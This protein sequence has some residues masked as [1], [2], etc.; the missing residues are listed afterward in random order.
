[1]SFL[2]TVL[3]SVNGD[4]W[5]G[6]SVL[7]G[8]VAIIEDAEIGFATNPVAFLSAS[9]GEIRRSRVRHYRDEAVLDYG[10]DARVENCRIERGANLSANFGKRGV[11]S[12]FSQTW[13]RADTL[14]WHN[15]YAIWI[16]GSKSY[17][18]LTL[19]PGTP[20][21]TVLIQECVITGPG[22]TSTNLTGKGIY[23]D[24]VCQN[25]VAGISSNTLTQWS[26]EALYLFK[27]ADIGVA[28]NTIENNQYGVLYDRGSHL[29]PS[30]GPIRFL[31]NDIRKSDNRNLK[32]VAPVGLELRN[33]NPALAGENTFQTDVDPQNSKNIEY[34]TVGGAEIDALLHA[35]RRSDGSFMNDPQA[36]IDTTFVLGVTNEIAVDPLTLSDPACSRQAALVQAT[37]GLAP[38]MPPARIGAL[39]TSGSVPSELALHGPVPNPGRAGVE[40]TLD[41]PAAFAGEIRVVVYDV[42]GRRVRE[43]VN[44]S[45]SPG[46]HGVSWNGLDATGRAAAPGAY[47]VRMEA[48]E[49]HVN[50]RVLLLR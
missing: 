10:S 14:S 6:I 2:S 28:C 25:F 16:D 44:R 43:L 23:L 46:R 40:L 21:E 35:W 48:G 5:L 7:D 49:F 31:K 3:D 9:I 11:H 26:K 15:E 24:W 29:G 13:I 12:V 33:A 39:E 27:S 38:E 41:V 47:F 42:G 20:T 19:P 4:D 45:L 36:V 22:E 18:D 32:I 30:E 37:A 17:C 34:K 50:R 8:A 1:V